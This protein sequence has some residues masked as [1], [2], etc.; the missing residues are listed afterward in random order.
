[1]AAV[2]LGNPCG[3]NAR[4]IRNAMPLNGMMLA[5]LSSMVRIKQFAKRG[6]LKPGRR[7]EQLP[8]TNMDGFHRAVRAGVG[9]AELPSLNHC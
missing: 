7:P 6:T 1:M 4:H 9:V 8:R 2:L 5:E 3:A